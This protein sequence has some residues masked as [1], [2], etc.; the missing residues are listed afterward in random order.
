MLPIALQLSAEPPPSAALTLMGLL[1]GAAL[2]LFGLDRM[3]AALKRIAG[4]QLRRILSLLTG[5][6]LR[7]FVTGVGVTALTQSSTLVTVTLVGLASAGLLSLAQGIPV[8]LGANIGTTVTAQLIAFDIAGY[9]LWILAAAFVLSLLRRWPRVQLVGEALFGLGLMF[10]G[11]FILGSAMAPLKGQPQVL[12]LLAQTQHTLLGFGAGLLLAALIHSSAGTIGIAIALVSQD[13]IGLPAAVAICLGAELGTCVTALLAS[14]GRSVPAQRMALAQLMF[15]AISTLATLPFIAL[16][17]GLVE[18]LSENPPRQ[19][20]NAMTVF[21]V[22]W[23]LVFLALAGWLARLVTRL[24]PERPE[25]LGPLLPPKYLSADYLGEPELAFAMVRREL[26][27][28]GRRLEPQLAQLPAELQRLGP[29]ATSRIEHL[30]AEVGALY[31]QILAYLGRISAGQLDSAQAAQFLGLMRAASGLYQITH[32]LGNL[33]EDMAEDGIPL[34]PWVA[35]YAAPLHERVCAD[36]RLALRA[37][38]TR[39]LAAAQAVSREKPQIGALLRELRLRAAAEL[40]RQTPDAPVA[41][42]HGGASFETSYAQLMNLLEHL[43]RIFY[44]AR[45]S[46]RTVL[47]DDAEEEAERAAK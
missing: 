11:L 44:Y 23:A 12:E 47:P 30:H 45:R 33:T 2:L 31:D 5:T 24:L 42:N 36:L 41:R 6:R 1:G 9:S 40:S 27:R 29:Q 35:E 25:Q 15:N 22:L 16:L 18:P 7:G 39:D 13:L 19:I 38:E 43:K 46:A 21:N 28:I 17:L 20:A 4:P 8:I 10:L 3:S 37:I 14:L 32:L 34:P 26:G